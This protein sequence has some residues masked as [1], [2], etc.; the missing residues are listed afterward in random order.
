M[1]PT[2]RWV[3]WI[4]Q[5]SAPGIRRICMTP[6][7]GTIR[8]QMRTMTA[9]GSTA[10]HEEPDDGENPQADDEKAADHHVD[11]QQRE[12]VAGPEEDPEHQSAM[13]KQADEYAQDDDDLLHGGLAFDG[14]QPRLQAPRRKTSS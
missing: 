4:T 6:S 9:S 12:R 13:P 11:L 3:V 5:W 1:M 10:G 2:S 7:A 8:P 14:L